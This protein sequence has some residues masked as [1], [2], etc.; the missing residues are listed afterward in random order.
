MANLDDE[1]AAFQNEIAGLGDVDGGGDDEQSPETVNTAAAVLLAAPT[2]AAAAPAPA[3]PRTQPTV[4]ASPIAFGTS[5]AGPTKGPSV[6]AVVTKP[7]EKGPIDRS[8]ATATAK[9][10]HSLQPSLPPPMP[11]SSGPNLPGYMVPP[12]PSQPRGHSQPVIGVPPF[13]PPHITGD[14]A[15]RVASIHA[16]VQA[17]QAADAATA[18][19]ET[20][21]YKRVCPDGE[22]WHD[23]TLTEWPENDYRIFVGDLDNLTGDDA[24]GQ[25]FSQYASFARAKVIKDNRTGKSKGYGF[26]SLLDPRDYAKALKQMQ[27][28]YI[29]S[30]P[31]KVRKCEWKEKNSSEKPQVVR[32]RAKAK[33]PGKMTASDPSYTAGGHGHGHQLHHHRQQQQQ[34]QQQRYQQMYNKR[35]PARR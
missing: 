7:P 17:K 33:R 26:V 21:A 15:T 25:A 27:G 24:L 31:C 3:P 23:P 19:G 32:E 34:L 35:P 11:G 29:G 20:L 1:F 18:R 5:F 13:L 9:A 10:A 14:S 30:R 2:A 12:L 22:K 8:K 16:S 6:A 28:K 4:S